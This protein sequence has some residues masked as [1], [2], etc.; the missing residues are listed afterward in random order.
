M[1]ESALLRPIDAGN[2]LE[3]TVARLLQTVRLGVVPPGEALPSERE[4]ALGFS[5]SRDTVREAIRELS[6]AGWLVA[7][8]GRYG[9]TFVV[10]PPPAISARPESGE[11]EEVLGLREVLEPGAA[12]VAANRALSATECGALWAA[13]RDCAAAAEADYRRLDSLLHLS[14]AEF[15]GLPQLVALIA[16]NRTRVNEFLDTFPLLPRNIQHSTA[17]HERIVRAI[18]DGHPDE[19][20]ACM[21]EH[22]AGSAELLRGFLS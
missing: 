10:D 11:L 6:G 20:E 17:Q 21:R 9:G 1:L 13:H 22:L 14:I 12:R 5:V 18:V 2:A 4:L 8:R 7:R 16:E 15:S 19:A 3:H